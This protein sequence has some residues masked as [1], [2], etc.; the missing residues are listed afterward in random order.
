MV[1][2]NKDAGVSYFAKLE[3]QAND[4]ESAYIVSKKYAENKN[5]VK[6]AIWCIKAAEYGY[7]KAYEDAAG[8]LIAGESIPGDFKKGLSYYKKAEESG[9]LSDLGK[10]NYA[11]DLRRYGNERS[12]E[13]KIL[14]LARNVT[15]VNNLPEWSRDFLF[16]VAA[17]IEL[18]S[19]D[20][21]DNAIEYW[22]KVV[23]KKD[24][25]DVHSDVEREFN[26]LDA[27]IPKLK[28]ENAP[29]SNEDV[30][31]DFKGF[32]FSNFPQQEGYKSIWESFSAF[33]ADPVWN[34]YRMEKY[35]NTYA[36]VFKGISS[37]RGVKR[38]YE[39]PFVLKYKNGLPKFEPGQYY[40]LFCKANGKLLSGDDYTDIL[41]TI[42][43]E[44]KM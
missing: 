44:T 29:K 9:T 34:V 18:N 32:Y 7:K 20:N 1:D 37:Y 38:L 13:K 33:F 42:M 14:D 2:D 28:A 19:N 12:G 15:L 16:I 23:N 39:Y 4:G 25:R 35:K 17:Y 36:I 21:A 5:T 6:S 43:L 40:G 22:D 3:S 27:R 26:Y 30:L 31:H 24:F 10:V 41:Y 8:L 11:L